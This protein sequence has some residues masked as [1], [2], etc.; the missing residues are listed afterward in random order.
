MSQVPEVIQDFNASLRLEDQYEAKNLIVDDE[1]AAEFALTQ[2]QRASISS[3]YLVFDC[4]LNLPLL[5]EGLLDG[6]EIHF[7]SF[8]F[9]YLLEYLRQ[10]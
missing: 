10:S 6:I 3:S 2:V 4:L 9:Y 1:A 5:K 8:V 7:I